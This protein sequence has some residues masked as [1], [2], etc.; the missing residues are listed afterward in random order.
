MEGKLKGKRIL[1]RRTRRW[2]MDMALDV[3]EIGW[4]D[5]ERIRMSQNGDKCRTL[6]REKLQFA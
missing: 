2:D 3:K 1:G 6:K 4:E 5:V